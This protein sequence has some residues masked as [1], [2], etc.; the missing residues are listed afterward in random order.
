M[1]IEDIRQTVNSETRRRRK[2]TKAIKT[3]PW[4]EEE[5]YQVM[6]L[7]RKHGPQKWT[8]IA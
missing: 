3:G 6:E 5:D 8:F 7:V 2:N 4:T 1:W